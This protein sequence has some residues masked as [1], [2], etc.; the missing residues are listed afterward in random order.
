MCDRFIT[1]FVAG[2]MRG[3]LL[4]MGLVPDGRGNEWA[5]SGSCRQK[6]LA[7]LS[8]D[9]CD[10]SIEIADEFQLPSGAH[11]AVDR[12]EAQRAGDAPVRKPHR[13]AEAPGT[14]NDAAGIERIALPAR[15]SDVV[16]DLL[17]RI[18][19]IVDFENLPVRGEDGLHFV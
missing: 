15:C 6:H 18:I 4:F 7:E 14:G 17:H 13:K 12:S 3:G 1:R 8:L 9:V 11:A 5:W 10:L 19:S 2:V 16:A